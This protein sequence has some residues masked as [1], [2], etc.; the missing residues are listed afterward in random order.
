MLCMQGQSREREC[1]IPFLREASTALHLQ[2]PGKVANLASYQNYLLG[3]VGKLGGNWEGA[4]VKVGC[5]SM[6]TL[7]EVREGTPCPAAPAPPE[8]QLITAHPHQV[9]VNKYI[10]IH[11]CVYICVCISKGV[12]V[13]GPLEI[14]A[15][16]G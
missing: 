1:C 10:Y 5:A 14:P 7:R 13:H 15:E 4:G 8:Q 9:H 6:G 3:M 2:A 12:F 11:M 16:L